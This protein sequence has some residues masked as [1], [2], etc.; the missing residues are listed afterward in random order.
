MTYSDAFLSDHEWKLKM[1]AEGNAV[2]ILGKTAEEI[3]AEIGG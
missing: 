2:Y 1:A 3:K